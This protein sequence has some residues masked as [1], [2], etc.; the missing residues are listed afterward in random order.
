VEPKEDIMIHPLCILDGKVNLL[1]NKA[2]EKV[3]VQWTHYNPED[4]TWEL[5]DTMREAYP[6][7]F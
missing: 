7:I 4:A 1:R 5:E 6:H 3:K 2:I